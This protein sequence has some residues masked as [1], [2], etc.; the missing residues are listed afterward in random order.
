MHSFTPSP[1]PRRFL[2]ALLPLLLACTGAPDD[3][4]DTGDTGDTADTDACDTPSDPT[5]TSSEGPVAFAD[6][7]DTC[8]RRWDE[9]DVGDWANGGGCGWGYV[10]LQDPDKVLSIQLDLPVADLDADHDWV[11]SLAVGAGAVLEIGDLDGGADEIDFWSCSDYVE[12]FAGTLW[13]GVAGR[14]EVEARW[15]CD[16]VDPTC[17]D[18]EV[19]FHTRVSLVGVAVENGAGECMDVPDTEFSVL[20]GTTDCGG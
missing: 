16:T 18:D 14:V 15:V 19:E 3:T 7:D 6:A 2:Q 12:Q 10:Y 17:G 4:G 20:F 5:T 9:A 1:L 11:Y 8:D 13:T